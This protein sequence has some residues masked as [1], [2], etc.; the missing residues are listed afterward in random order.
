MHGLCIKDELEQIRRNAAEDARMH[1]R[2]L[3]S[4]MTREGII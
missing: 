1:L 3:V 4:E 2:V